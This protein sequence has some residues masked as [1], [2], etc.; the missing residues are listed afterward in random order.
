MNSTFPHSLLFSLLF[1]SLVNRYGESRVQEFTRYPYMNVTGGEDNP[2]YNNRS[3]SYTETVVND[4]FLTIK[5]RNMCKFADCKEEDAGVI[6]DSLALST[7]QKCYSSNQAIDVV[8]ADASILELKILQM[9]CSNVI[10]PATGESTSV[11]VD[12]SSS[13]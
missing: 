8:V 7:E 11:S 1:S 4:S 13:P 9:D 10:N 5:Y 2:N 12:W 6:G 3:H